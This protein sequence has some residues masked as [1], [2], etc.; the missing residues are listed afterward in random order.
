[1]NDKQNPANSQIPSSP[2]NDSHQD[3]PPPPVPTSP[4]GISY[5]ADIE[6]PVKEEQ[7]HLNPA[8]VS[9]PESI[10]PL[11][12]GSSNKTKL[13]GAIAAIILLV[14]AI[15]AGIFLIGR[16]QDVREKAAGGDP[17]HCGASDSTQRNQGLVVGNCTGWRE[18]NNSCA[19][20]LENPYYY[21]SCTPAT[22]PDG[23]ARVS[24][25]VQCMDETQKQEA[26]NIGFNA[27]CYAGANPAESI[28]ISVNRCG[29]P[30][31]PPTT[32]THPDG[33]ARPDDTVQCLSSNQQKEMR[34][35]GFNAACYTTTGNPAESV[36]ISENRCPLYKHLDGCAGYG[37]TVQ[38]MDETQKQEARNIGFNAVCYTPENKPAESILVQNN[39]CGAPYNPP[40]TNIISVSNIS[41]NPVVYG[42]PVKF[43]ATFSGPQAAKVHV[44]IWPNDAAGVI[45]MDGGKITTSGQEISFNTG[46]FPAGTTTA[47]V[48]FQLQNSS[49]VDLIPNV[50]QDETLTV[51]G[52]GAGAGSN[53]TLCSTIELIKANSIVFESSPGNNQPVIN[54]GESFQVRVMC[55]L[56]DP[57]DNFDKIQVKIT[58]PSGASTQE[59]VASRFQ[60]RDRG[61]SRAFFA[62]FD[63]TTGSSGNY[64]IKAW[65]HTPIKGWKGKE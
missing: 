59:K 36:K 12:V 35:R 37:D 8:S 28:L 40:G 23:C 45:A 6:A 60:E 42:Q 62:I 49:N 48:R 24:D 20:D 46:S 2:V 21:D 51:T 3:I 43:K 22:H 54:P 9:V 50:A 52:S 11:P 61:A 57:A 27:V 14:V 34:N 64:N 19:A 65:G 32:T 4:P 31:V 53:A 38:C 5:N 25:T 16:N 33:C 10:S 41:P 44:R 13:Y 29:A 47:K 26:R 15:P 39:R 17:L 18:T 30:Y 58:T 7:A 55:T 1:M 63:L 56:T